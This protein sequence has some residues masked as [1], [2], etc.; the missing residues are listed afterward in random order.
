M[1]TKLKATRQAVTYFCGA[2][3][4]LNDLNAISSNHNTQGTSHGPNVKPADDRRQQQN[5]GPGSAQA[6]AQA[7]ESQPST[8]KHLSV[9]NLVDLGAELAQNGPES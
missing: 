1:Q 8:K 4:V 2:H 5:Q 9:P 3:V 7:P 6:P